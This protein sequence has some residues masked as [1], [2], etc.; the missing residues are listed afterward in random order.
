[1]AFPAG[2]CNTKASSTAWLLL[3]LPPV[4]PASALPQHPSNAQ[5][6]LPAQEGN[7]LNCFVAAVAGTKAVGDGL[8]GIPNTRAGVL[9][10]QNSHEAR[11]GESSSVQQPAPDGTGHF[12]TSTSCSPSPLLPAESC[13]FLGGFVLLCTPTAF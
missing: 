8:H 7:N 2:G 5:T 6:L 10:G 13:S 12:Q 1:M 3:C 11:R 9:S 4:T